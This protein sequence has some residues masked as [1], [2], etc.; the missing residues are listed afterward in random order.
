MFF[1]E[2]FVKQPDFKQIQIENK[3]NQKSQYHLAYVHPITSVCIRKRIHLFLN[4]T[5]KISFMDNF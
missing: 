2:Y 1:R 5:R 4:I 3:T